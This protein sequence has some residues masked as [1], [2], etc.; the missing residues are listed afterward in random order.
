MTYEEF[1][2]KFP[3]FEL[4]D[5]VIVESMIEQVTLEHNS[6]AG[7]PIEVQPQ[8][9][10]LASAHYLVVEQKVGGADATGDVKR[11][12]SRNDEIE[13]AKANSSPNDWAL[14]SYGIR[15]QRLLTNF[16]CIGSVI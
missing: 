5:Q 11:I 9:I 12:K 13:Y 15:L 16:Y 4:L 1:I 10:A 14:T 2:A 3:A 8:A 7:L 6:F